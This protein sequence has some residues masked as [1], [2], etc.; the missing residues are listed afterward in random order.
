MGLKHVDDKAMRINVDVFE[1]KLPRTPHMFAFQWQWNFQFFLDS[2]MISNE[3]C[4][5]DCT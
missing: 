2:L 3:L 5:H 1:L 4:M